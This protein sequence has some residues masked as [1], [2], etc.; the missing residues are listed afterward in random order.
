MKRILIIITIII[1][2]V[3]IVNAAAPSRGY[4]GFI[5]I[6]KSF[7]VHNGG[8]DPCSKL[9]MSAST[10]H[11]YQLNSHLFT[12]I[13]FEVP[14]TDYHNLS[15][16]IFA[17]VRTDWDF[18][19]ISPYAQLNIGGVAANL[20]AFYLA[21]SIGYRFAF[22]R[23]CALNIGV[24]FDIRLTNEDHYKFFQYPDEQWSWDNQGYY[25]I[26]GKRNLSSFTISVSFEF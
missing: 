1:S 8:L 11:G 16:P 26:V 15:F 21:P 10:T 20:P 17:S 12:G 13:G 25:D 22:S 14:F 2:C 24:G 7:T 23:H 4:R 9:Q 3:G 6:N 5:N 19:G 18:N